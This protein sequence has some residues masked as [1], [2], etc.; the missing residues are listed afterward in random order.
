MQQT[1]VKAVLSEDFERLL[2]VL[3]VLEDFKAGQSRCATCHDV[4]TADNVREVFPLP[5][6]QVG[7]HCS[8]LECRL[9]AV[10]MPCNGT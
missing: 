4:V 8:K 5:N 10:V 2:E 6:Y 9:A 7:F 1:T 3:G